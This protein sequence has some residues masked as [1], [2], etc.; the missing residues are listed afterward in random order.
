MAGAH[1]VSKAYMAQNNRCYS[2]PDKQSDGWKWKFEV[3]NVA[4]LTATIDNDLEDDT[5]VS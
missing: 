3:I 4:H 2:D 1:T 5:D